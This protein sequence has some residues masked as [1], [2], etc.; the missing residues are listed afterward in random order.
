MGTHDSGNGWCEV[1]AF[2]EFN[3]EA[4]AIGF[5]QHSTRWSTICKAS[6]Q[7]NSVAHLNLS[8]PRISFPRHSP[9]YESPLRRVCVPMPN[10]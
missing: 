4:L 7:D 2:V 3:L 1:A 9:T 8:C 10:L 5:R 6:F